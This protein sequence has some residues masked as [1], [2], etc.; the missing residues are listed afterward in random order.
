VVFFTCQV[1]FLLYLIAR[2]SLFL[3]QKLSEITSHFSFIQGGTRKLTW[4]IGEWQLLTCQKLMVGTQ[5]LPFRLMTVE[6]GLGWRGSTWADDPS[7]V[8]SSWHYN[9]SNCPCWRSQSEASSSW[10]HSPTI[11]ARISNQ[12]L[13]P[14]DN[15]VI[16]TS[17]EL[18]KV[19]GAPVW[20]E[21]MVEGAEI[22]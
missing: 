20:L 1:S 13:L 19:L 21:A 15:S 17:L 11:L 5:S 4:D 6:E 16:P 12:T 2:E 14:Q 22:D 10:H 9:Q 18:W 7:E 8:T 3:F